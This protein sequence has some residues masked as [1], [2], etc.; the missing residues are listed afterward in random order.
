MGDSKPGFFAVA[1]PPDANNQGLLEFLIKPQPDSTADLVANLKAGAEVS[2]SPV[3]GKGFPVDKIPA[4]DFPTV[5]IFA[6]GASAKP[7]M[8]AC[9]LWLQDASNSNASNDSM[10]LLGTELWFSCSVSRRR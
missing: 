10:L 8:A 5:I 2:V 3:Q 7:A 4:A 6:T 9:L 1:S